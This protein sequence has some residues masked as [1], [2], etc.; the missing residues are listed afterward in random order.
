M[1]LSS[2]WPGSILFSMPSRP[3]ISMAAERQVRIAGRVGRT[4]LHALRL[5]RGRVH[6]DAARRRTVAARV[7]Q[8]HR[9]FEAR[10]QALVGVGGGSDDRRQ[11]R[12]VLDQAADV[13]Q[14]HLRQAGIAVAGEQRLAVLPQRLVGVHAA[15][16]VPEERLGH[17][18][19]GL[20]VLVGDVLR[21]CTCRAS[22]RRP[23]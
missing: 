22:C 14:R 2:G 10:H 11:R 8:V 5:G 21:R 16:V 4:E 6:R 1:S 12:P 23:T 9:R 3:A 15:A 20:A 19:H 13:P 18:G 17:E 7:R